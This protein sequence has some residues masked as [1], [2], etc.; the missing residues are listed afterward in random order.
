[1]QITR[2]SV[3]TGTTRTREIPADPEHM[4]LYQLDMGNIED[5]MPYLSDSDREFIRT[6]ITEGEWKRAFAESI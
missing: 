5:L 3:L 6:G 1:M 4:T 2:K